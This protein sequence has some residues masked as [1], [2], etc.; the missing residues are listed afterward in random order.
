M[1]SLCQV[2]GSKLGILLSAVVRGLGVPQ[3]HRQSIFVVGGEGPG[4]NGGAWFGVGASRAVGTKGAL[5]VL[6]KGETTKRPS[7]NS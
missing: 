7:I 4:S 2:G 1:G 5:W 6:G 3:G